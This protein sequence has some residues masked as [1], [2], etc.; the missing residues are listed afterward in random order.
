MS[1]FIQHYGYWALFLLA[2]A[3]SALVPIPSE[4]TFGFAGAY[5]TTAVAGS[6]HFSLV[7]VIV[8]GTVGSVVGSVVAY[9]VGRYLGR[10]IVDR[11]GK[12][13]L[14]THHDLDVAE[15]WFTKFGDISVL[16]GRFMPVVRTVI[17]LPA[18]LAEMRRRHFFW[19]TLVG[20]LG[21]V[22]LLA[23]LGYSAG[24]S[25]NHISHD[26]HLFQTPIIVLI[27]LAIAAFFWNR[28]RTIRRH[29]A[30]ANSADASRNSSGRGKHSR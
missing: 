5:S 3:E 8:I 6:A 13:I 20:S 10:P 27:V 22:A 18:G 7:W 16:I 11:Y 4:V 12:W 23:G 14:L 2:A 15:R 25:W 24:S 30:G 21:W 19:M 26:V 29:G 1:S 17:S 28:V 9:E